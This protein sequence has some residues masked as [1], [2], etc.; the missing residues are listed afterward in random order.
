[1][2]LKK[3]TKINDISLKTAQRLSNVFNDEGFET[4]IVP[5]YISSVGESYNNYEIHIYKQTRRESRWYTIM[6]NK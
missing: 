5:T 3:I 2:K 1:M 4:E 6:F